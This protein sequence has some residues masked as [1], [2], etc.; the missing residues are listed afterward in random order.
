LSLWLGVGFGVNFTG[1][2]LSFWK[3]VKSSGMGILLLP[4]CLFLVSCSTT[5]YKGSPDFSVAETRLDLAKQSASPEVRK[6][7]EEAQKQRKSAKDLCLTNSQQLEEAVRERNEALAKAEYWKEKQ[8]KALKE[9]WF[10][11]GALIV[12]VLFAARGPILWLVRKF[13]G[14]PW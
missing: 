14:I 7:I 3:S 8:R 4:L 11:R 2:S 13:V 12:A 9:L 6:H 1:I 10:W 5:S